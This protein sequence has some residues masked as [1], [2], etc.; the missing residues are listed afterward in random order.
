MLMILLPVDCTAADHISDQSLFLF[1]IS[2]RLRLAHSHYLYAVS[3]VAKC[4]RREMRTGAVITV[5]QYDN[6]FT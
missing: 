3:Q 5:I 6:K 4:K 1:F 2:F